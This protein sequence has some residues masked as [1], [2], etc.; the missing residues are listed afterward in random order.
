MWFGVKKSKESDPS[1][2]NPI[3]VYRREMLNVNPAYIWVNLSIF[4]FVS[5]VFLSYTFY[6]QSFN[7]KLSIFII[8]RY[9]ECI[10]FELNHSVFK[11]KIISSTP[12][13]S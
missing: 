1:A 3:D 4:L 8:R 5:N 12:F 10:A 6:L 11:P 9:P 2:A 7:I 13:Q